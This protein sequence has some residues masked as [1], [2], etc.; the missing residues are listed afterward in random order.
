MIRRRSPARS[1]RRGFT[2]IEAIA[3]IVVLAIIGSI[4]SLIILTAVDGYTDAA[5]GAQLHIE[6]STAMDRIVRELRK[7]ALD[8]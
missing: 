3:T 4:A 6:A 8:S 5:T 1:V 7:V 2:L